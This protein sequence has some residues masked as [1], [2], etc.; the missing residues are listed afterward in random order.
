MLSLRKIV[1][2]CKIITIKAIPANKKSGR[3]E[4]RLIANEVPRREG[5][6]KLTSN[7]RAS[8]RLLL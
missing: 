1:R 8:I 3:P 6:P 7:C 4:M 2:T 5:H